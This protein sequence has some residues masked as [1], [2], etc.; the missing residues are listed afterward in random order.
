MILPVQEEQECN[1]KLGSWA[2]DGNII[3]LALFNNKEN[4]DLS[5]F[6]NGSSPYVVTRH[7]EGTRVVKK[8]D[9]CEEPYP[10]LNFR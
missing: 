5:E 1:I 8:Y 9:C 6:Y 7:M 2:H 3:D 4:M 10:S